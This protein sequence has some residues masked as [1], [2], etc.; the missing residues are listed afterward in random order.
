MTS[1]WVFD[2]AITQNISEQRQVSL[3][4]LLQDLRPALPLKTALD[5]GCGIGHFSKHLADLGLTVTGIDARADNIAEAHKR[6]AGIDFQA[7]DIED[8]S[9]QRLGKFDFILC[10][11]LLYHLENPFRAV[12]NLAALTGSVLMIESMVAPNS[13]LSS[14]SKLLIPPGTLPAKFTTAGAFFVNNV[15]SSELMEVLCSTVSRTL[16]R[17]PTTIV[18]LSRAEIA[19]SFLISTSFIGSSGPALVFLSW[20][21]M[22]FAEIT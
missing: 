21:A 4:A 14:G 6:Y 8:P 7:Q 13:S 17:L 16:F 3:D 19:I 2:Q 20:S 1:E 15:A 12:R 11:G 5:A 22:S 18:V 9:I 10:F